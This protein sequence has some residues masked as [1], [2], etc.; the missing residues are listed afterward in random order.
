MDGGRF[1]LLPVGK[2]SAVKEGERI[3]IAGV[4]DQFK[5]L[6]DQLIIQRRA[7]L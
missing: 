1:A 2:R 6:A 4:H 7:V 3:I 5:A